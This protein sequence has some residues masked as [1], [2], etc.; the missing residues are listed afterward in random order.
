MSPFFTAI[1]FWDLRCETHQGSKCTQHGVEQHRQ[2]A[3]HSN[4][5]LS[6]IHSTVTAFFH[7][8][9]YIK[10]AFYVLMCH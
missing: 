9:M 10:L 3:L 4:L 6:T 2:T 1:K 5:T 8:S 7:P